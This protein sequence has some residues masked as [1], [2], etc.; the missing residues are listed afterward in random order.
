MA[1]NP[2]RV[3]PLMAFAAPA[4]LSNLVHA[5]ASAVVPTLYST[6]FGL[7]L[8]LIGTALL[9]SRSA[10]VVLDP[11][12]GFL[13]DRTGGRLGARK[14]WII[15]GGLLSMV[16][17]WFLFVPPTHPSFGYFLIWYTLIYIAWSMI[18]IPHQAWGFEITRA[19]AARARVLTFRGLALGIAALGYL[20]LPLLPIFK[21]TAV[22]AE[23]LRTLAWLVLVL[24]PI[25]LIAALWAP[26]GIPVL[27][28]DRYRLADLVSIVRGNRPLWMFLTG[29]VLFG[30]SVGMFGTLTFLYLA[31]YLGLGKQFVVIFGFMTICQLAALPLAPFAI[32]RLGNRET[33][34][35]A[36]LLGL[37]TFPVI[38]L[39][40][41]GEAAFLPML[42]LGVP[43][44][45]SNALTLIGYSSVLGDVIDYD[46]WRTGKKRAAV[47]SALLAFVQKLNT[48]PGG[49][50]AL[51]IVGLV[52]YRPALGPANS[53]H[54]I[55]GLKVAYVV[56]PVVL[57][58]LSILF[59][60]FS[61]IDR[62]RQGIIA[63]RLGQREARQARDQ[64]AELRPAGERL[65]PAIVPG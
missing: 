4:F 26:S 22:T 62:R 18:E 32:R 29:F 25:G 6:E 8:T 19:P 41:K 50:L 61:P 14:P 28:K 64:E 40:P 46:T 12:I 21:T 34:A 13:S 55:L 59:A 45:I 11:L 23:T 15:A 16:S 47:Y 37:V 17:A 39:L 60:W 65:E 31:N 49:A 24:T 56:A 57:F 42:A 43:I 63:R 5:P 10:D 52:G 9:I 1:R 54:A 7:S 36:M 48:I 51:I 30:L 53:P 20:V 33:W 2:L 44:G 27:H 38:L 58:G 35:G 3:L